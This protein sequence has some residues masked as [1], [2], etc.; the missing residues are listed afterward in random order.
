MNNISPPTKVDNLEGSNPLSTPTDLLR[1]EPRA[2]FLA[3][4][5]LRF[6]SSALFLRLLT[7]NLIGPVSKHWLPGPSPGRGLLKATLVLPSRPLRAVRVTGLNLSVLP[8]PKNL[9]TKQTLR[10]RKA[11]TKTAP[12]P[13]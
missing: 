12:T 10:I 3:T 8:N 5:T 9:H 1:I 4:A 2:A 13:S 6:L 11:K 7:L